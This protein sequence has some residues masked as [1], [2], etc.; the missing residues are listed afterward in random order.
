MNGSESKKRNEAIE[1]VKAY[2]NDGEFEKDLDNPIRFRTG[3][4]YQVIENF[5]VRGGF[6]T[7]P[8]EL[9][10]GFGYQFKEIQ[11][12]LGSAYHQVLGWSPHFSFVFQSK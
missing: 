9:T 7:A 10:L 6:A 1:Y 12:S 4:E 11:L 2:F 3:L 5:F 8:V